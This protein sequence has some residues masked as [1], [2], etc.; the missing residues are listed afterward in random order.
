MTTT[1]EEREPSY[2]FIN[3]HTYHGELTDDERMAVD[4]F[5]AAHEI[6]KDL[7]PYLTI[8]Y[9]GNE[10][11]VGVFLPNSAGELVV[12]GVPDGTERVKQTTVTIPDESP[13]DYL[14]AE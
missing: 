6:D 3:A 7:V 10:T 2:E 12:E 9:E 4:R 13:W 1:I 8:D 5:L 11:R 14:E